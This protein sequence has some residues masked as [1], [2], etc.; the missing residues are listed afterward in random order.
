MRTPEMVEVE[1]SIVGLRCRRC[2]VTAP[3]PT[4]V[5]FNRFL[6]RH[7]DHGGVVYQAKI[8][9]PP[10]LVADEIVELEMTKGSIQ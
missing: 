5:E 4:E 8:M 7:G 6:L 3:T 2:A 1:F 10:S 9:A